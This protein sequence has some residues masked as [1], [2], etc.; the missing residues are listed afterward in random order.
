MKIQLKKTIISHKNKISDW[1]Y[2]VTKY[3]CN[4]GSS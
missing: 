4:H 3:S 1:H 2:L